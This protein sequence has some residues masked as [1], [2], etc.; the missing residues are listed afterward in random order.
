MSGR[1]G[2]RSSCVC[3]L[4]GIEQ[5]KS[6]FVF[7][8]GKECFPGWLQRFQTD[9][10]KD[11]SWQPGPEQRAGVVDHIKGAAEKVIVWA[12]RVEVVHACGI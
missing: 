1:N 5:V 3:E 6:F 7:V 11:L 4:G 12:V 10:R 2:R 8:G 9:V